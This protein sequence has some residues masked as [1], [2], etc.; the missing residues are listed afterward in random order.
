MMLRQGVLS[1]FLF[2]SRVGGP[3]SGLQRNSRTKR[4][5]T[6]PVARETATNMAAR[7]ILQKREESQLSRGLSRQQAILALP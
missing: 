7:H 5:Q 1:Q 6:Q 3:S 2:T 4:Y